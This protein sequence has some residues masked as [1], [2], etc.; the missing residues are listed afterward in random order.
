MEIINKVIKH[1]AQTSN[2]ISTQNQRV[3]PQLEA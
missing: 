3:S 1:L 2:E